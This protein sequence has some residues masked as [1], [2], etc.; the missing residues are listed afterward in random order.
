MIGKLKFIKPFMINEESNYDFFNQKFFI[1]RLEKGYGITIGNSLRRVLLSSLPGSAIVNVYI[2]GVEHEF[3]VIP[4]V[5]EDV[6]TIVLNLK[7]VV[8][9]VDSQDDEFEAKLE[10][11]VKGKEIITA[12]DFQI[13]EEGIKIINK[14]QIIAH[15]ADEN[16]HFKM[17]V[18]IRRGIG[19]VS[20]EDNK[21]YSKNKFGVI[22]MDSLYTPVL[23]VTYSVEQKLNNKEELILE[24]ETN[25]SISSKEALATASKILADHFYALSELSEK[26]KNIDFIYEPEIKSY[27][28]ALD[29]RIDHLEVSV[30]LFNSLKKSGINTIKELVNQ[31]EKNISKLN[32]LG[33]KSFEELKKK[34]KELDLHFKS[35]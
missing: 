23:R 17:E 15:L 10:I 33:K 22:S 19:Y 34:M 31:T 16:V 14:E 2:H 27:N 12:K 8:I 25:K 26:A 9:S 21:I 24:I 4:G 3:N 6:M 32:S 13:L 5:Y 29:M 35:D 30:R 1:Q 18:T 20:A 11:D 7:K 28:H